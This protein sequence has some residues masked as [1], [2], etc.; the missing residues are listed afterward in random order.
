MNKA[1][2]RKQLIQKRDLI[3]QTRREEAESL[4]FHKLMDSS[5]LDG[6]KIVYAYMAKGSEVCVTSFLKEAQKQGIKVALP[7]SRPKT[8]ALDFYTVDNLDDLILGTYN[9]LEPK[10]D[11]EKLVSRTN[12]KSSICLVPGLSF[13]S[14]G[15]R[16][17]YGAGYYDRFLSEY[18]GISIGVC[19]KELYVAS[20][21][22]LDAKEKFDI[23]TDK[24][25]VG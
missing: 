25:I 20:L 2:L 1:K 11:K 8:H 12:D 23:P 14:L 4:V 10:E 9:I 21:E 3:S 15:Y 7:V 18:K 22:N 24:V 6:C 16:L 5:Y 13:D 19:Y 17:G